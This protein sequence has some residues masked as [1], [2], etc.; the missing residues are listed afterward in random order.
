MAKKD[1]VEQC[2]QPTLYWQWLV[3]FVFVVAAV[4]VIVCIAI[5]PN[6][7]LSSL[8]VSGPI[9]QRQAQT[10][11]LTASST[12]GYPVAVMIDN[13]FDTW[14]SQYGLSQAPI[15]YSTLVEGGATRFL[16]VFD[17][18]IALD[19]IG[20]IRSVRPYHLPLVAEYDALLAHVGGSPQA[21][22]DIVTYDILDLNEMTSYGP[23]YFTRE[24]AFD[25]PHNT[26]T[27]TL[28]LQQALQDSYVTESRGVL[29]DHFGTALFKSSAN[30]GVTANYVSIDYS[31]RST[32]DVE[33]KWQ[34][35]T[36]SYYRYQAGELQYDAAFDTPLQIQAL[37][38]QKM[39]AETILDQ[40]LRID[41]DMVGEG[42]LLYVHN[43]VVETGYWKKESYTKPTQYFDADYMPLLFQSDSIWIELV[44]NGH[45]ITV[46]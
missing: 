7:L 43:G 28:Q 1:I 14:E 23:L 21:L 41:I 32:Y 10:T 12:I 29:F 8:P 22:E 39:P 18:Q 5:K 45:A 9:V 3:V 34:P 11:A 30:N 26:F 36:Q 40:L 20:P 24:N 15:V 19:R 4:S 13:H 16:A 17:S 38:L 37:I 27:S 33:Y 2:N 6:P 31:A 35:D 25:E 44:P 46:E 42:E